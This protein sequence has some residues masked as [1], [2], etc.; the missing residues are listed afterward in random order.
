VL[1]KIGKKATAT[2]Q[3]ITSK[4]SGGRAKP[5]QKGKGKI[6][7]GEGENMIRKRKRKGSELPYL[8]EISKPPED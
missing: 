6:R 3:A 2:R 1:N 8:R 4:G 5:I 7:N